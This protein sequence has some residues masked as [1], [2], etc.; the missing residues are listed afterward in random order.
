MAKLEPG[1]SR[2]IT[3]LYI[4]IYWS[5]SNYFQVAG[6]SFL[7]VYYTLIITS[8]Y[9]SGNLTYKSYRLNSI[10]LSYFHGGWNLVLTGNSFVHIA[11][12]DH[13]DGEKGLGRLKPN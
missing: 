10:K 4:S 2:T 8:S 12:S 6:E 11:M 5:I 3:A 13:W 9:T 7:V 1:S